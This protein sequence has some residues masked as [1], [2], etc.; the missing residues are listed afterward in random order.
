M[1]FYEIVRKM[2]IPLHRILERAGKLR[3]GDNP[4][5]M[6]EEKDRCASTMIAIAM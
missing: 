1:I 2:A 5:S 6:D 3:A 4:D